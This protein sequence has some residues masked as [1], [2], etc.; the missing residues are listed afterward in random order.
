VRPRRPRHD[1]WRRYER[2][3]PTTTRSGGSGV[4]GVG[5]GG[6]TAAACDSKN[7]KLPELGFHAVVGD[8]T[9]GLRFE[10]LLAR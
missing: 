6:G 3:A 8:D 4:C 1:P 7:T 2:G 9:R 10:R 5:D